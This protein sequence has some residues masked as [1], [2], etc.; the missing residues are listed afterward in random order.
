MFKPQ[1][2]EPSDELIFA[3]RMVSDD[4]NNANRSFVL[5][6]AMDSDE[7]KI[8]ENTTTG[9]RGGFYYV[10]PHYREI[11]SFDPA[12]AF[13]GSIINVNGVDFELIDADEGTLSIMESSPSEFP[14][15]DLTEV[16]AQLRLN[17]KAKPLLTSKFEAADKEKIGRVLMK[18]VVEI[19][20]DPELNL[21]R[22]QIRTIC[23]RFRFYQTERFMYE[24]LLECF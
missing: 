2:E 8:W 19:L 6:M 3:A 11:G 7:I 15:A 9:F 5:R 23:R 4:P 12:K 22:Q 18:D 1:K 13:L 21:N 16:M 17:D 14:F 24:Q 20:S 10:S